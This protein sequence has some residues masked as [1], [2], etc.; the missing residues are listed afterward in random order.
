M[1]SYPA[2]TGRKLVAG[3]G[4]VA[5]YS[6][7]AYGS[8][9]SMTFSQ[10]QNFKEGATLYVPG[11]ADAK[12]TIDRGNG[13]TWQMKQPVV[14]YVAPTGAF[15]TSDPSTSRARGGTGN[16]SGIIIPNARHFI[17]VRHLDDA[18]A[19]DAYVYFDTLF[20]EKGVH[21]YTKDRCYG[22]AYAEPSRICPIGDGNI[23]MSQWGFGTVCATCGRLGVPYDYTSPS[24]FGA[25]AALFGIFSNL[26]DRLAAMDS[27]SRVTG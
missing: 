27:M 8:P 5:S 17:Y 10:A 7:G 15:Y 14:G 3:S 1:A 24:P 6:S 18:G 22:S 19:P 25:W 21:P 2:K 16:T 23:A 4:T 11:Y 12:F 13:L 9:V 20:P 26:G